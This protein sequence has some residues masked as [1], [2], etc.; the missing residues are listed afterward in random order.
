MKISGARLG[1][2]RIQLRVPSVED[3]YM[4][5]AIQYMIIYVFTGYRHRR[6]YV[7]YIPSH[8]DLQCPKRYLEMQINS[9]L[10]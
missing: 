2:R 4:L 5:L 1:T 8:L 9:L 7:V 3:P 6:S 10:G